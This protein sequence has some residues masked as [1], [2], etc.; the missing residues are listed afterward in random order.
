MNL[1]DM[2][3]NQ[4]GVSPAFR[5]AIS[6]DTAIAN[7]GAKLPFRGLLKDV[8][9]TQNGELLHRAEIDW[10]TDLNPVNVCGNVVEGYQALTRS[11]N[12]KVLS[13]TSNQFKP[14][15]NSDIMADMQALAAAGDAQICFAGSLDEGRKIVAIA[16]LEGEFTL[17]DKRQQKFAWNGHSGNRTAQDGE[18]K[19][20]LFVVISGGHEVGTPFKVRGMAF[21]KWCGNG[22]FFTCAAKSTYTRSHRVSIERESAKIAACYASIREEFGDYAFSAGRL[23]AIAMQ[24][25]QSRLYVAELLKPGLAETIGQ[26]LNAE[27]PLKAH[28]VWE[29]VAMS[30]RGRQALNEMLVQSSE[31]PGFARI[32]KTLLEAIMNQD[33]A[34]GDNLWSGYNG[35]TWHVDHKRGRSDESGVE[36]S[37]FGAG[38]DLKERALTTALRFAPVN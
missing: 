16:K 36:A 5:S 8:R 4:T 14:H 38:A 9:G 22:A 10:S 30:L 17:P 6:T 12:G 29:E 25:E 15:Q 3:V 24:R 2:I 19:T 13:I 32:G 28:E 26:R 37:L 18:D 21:R 20:A 31:E 1:L 27:N 35:I 7:F 34:N 11:D 33:G 23:Q